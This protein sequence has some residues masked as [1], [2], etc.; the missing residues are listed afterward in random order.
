MMGMMVLSVS[1]LWA[2][3]ASADL[4]ID[5]FS[6]ADWV[7]SLLMANGTTY[8]PWAGPAGTLSFT[9]IGGVG[10]GNYAAVFG[11]AWYSDFTLGSTG[12]ANA[13]SQHIAAADWP[14]EVTHFQFLVCNLTAGDLSEATR[15]WTFKWNI[16]AYSAHTATVTFPLPALA[17]G[18]SALVR[19]ALADITSTSGRTLGTEGNREFVGIAFADSGSNSYAYD[20]FAFVTVPEPTTMAL[21]GL[22]AIGMVLRRK[23]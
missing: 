1:L 8:A 7:S 12:G 14:T 3:P 10:T 6:D 11:G 4:L 2:G 5:N 16:G 19:I 20:D 18:E 13:T 22:G 9:E 17:A 23:K 15:K 21:L